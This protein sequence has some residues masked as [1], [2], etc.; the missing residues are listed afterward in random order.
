MTLGEQLQQTSSGILTL[1]LATSD[2]DL[3]LQLRT[4]LTTV[5]NQIDQL[6]AGNVNTNTAEYIAASNG[7][8]QA[9]TAI[10]EASNDLSQIAETIT[11]IS[12]AIEDVA[13]LATII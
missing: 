8:N 6:V 12:V 5:L 13:K 3:K 1:I 7:V 11:L 9:N 4:Q 10:T 2:V